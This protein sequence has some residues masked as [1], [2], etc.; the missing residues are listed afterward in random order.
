MDS[1]NEPE[2]LHLTLDEFL[3]RVS[4]PEPAPAGGSVAALAA[5]LAASLCVKAARLSTRHMNAAAELAT[6]AGGLRDRAASLCEDDAIV[7]AEVVGAQRAVTSASRDADLTAAL[8]AA[9]NVPLEIAVVAAEVADIAARLA[10]HGNENLVGDAVTAAALAE[11]ATRSA[12]TLVTINLAR[13]P[14]D[15]RHAR[16]TRL[17]AAAEASGARAR[18]VSP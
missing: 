15:A 17:V 8:S 18:R 12:A 1:A 9:A 6:R 5:A 10:D 11:A 13:W 2:F 16:V 7:Y 14:D 4:V 3:S